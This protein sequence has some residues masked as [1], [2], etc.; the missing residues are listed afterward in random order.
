MRIR[1]SKRIIHGC[2]S[3]GFGVLGMEEGREEPFQLHF[4]TAINVMEQQ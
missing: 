1:A 3:I 4:L 2:R